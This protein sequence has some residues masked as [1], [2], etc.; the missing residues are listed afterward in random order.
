MK[1]LTAI[2]TAALISLCFSVPAFAEP[3][4]SAVSVASVQSAEEQESAAQDSAAQSGGAVEESEESKPVRMMEYRIDEADMNI[5][6]PSDMYVITRNTDENDPV[7]SLNRTDKKKVMEEFEANDIYLRANAKDFSWVV[8]VM[9]SENEDTNTIGS[10][11]SISEKNLQQIIDKL[12]ESEIYTGC[13][14]NRFGGVLFLTFTI[15][16]NNGENNVTGIQEYTIINGKNVRITYQTVAPA[17]SDPNKARLN[18][19]M[20][21][22][23]FDG[24]EVEPSREDVSHSLSVADIDIRYIYIIAAS[25]IGVIALMIMIITGIKYKRSKKNALKRPS[26]PAPEPEKNDDPGE[27]IH[28]PVTVKD[29]E[30]FSDSP[31]EEGFVPS[32][33]SYKDIAEEEAESKPMTY[34]DLSKASFVNSLEDTGIIELPDENSYEA[35]A[36]KHAE[37]GILIKTAAD[38][39]DEKDENGENIVFARVEKRRT[40]IEQVGD[41]DKLSS[42]EPEKPEPEMSEQEKSE[43]EKPEPEKSEPEKSEQEKPEP[44]KPEQEKPEPEPEKTEERSLT[45]FE[46]RFGKFRPVPSAESEKQEIPSEEEIKVTRP[47]EESVSPEEKAEEVR[48]VEASFFNMMIDRLRTASDEVGR[49]ISKTERNENGT[50]LLPDDDKEI[51]Q[52]MTENSVDTKINEEKTGS[53]R[54]KEGNTIELEISRSEDGSLVI[55]ALNELSGKPVDIEIR[56]ASNFKEERDRKMAELGFETARDNEIYNAFKAEN[57]ENPFVVRAKDES[58]IAE[59]K[60]KAEQESLTPETEEEFFEGVKAVKSEPETAEK[61]AEKPEETKEDKDRADFERNCGIIFEH[62]LPKRNPIIPMQT[63]FTRIPRLDSVNAEEYNAK[64]E[65][66]VRSMPKNHAYA[67]RFSTSNIPQ[68]FVETARPHNTEAVFGQADYQPSEPELN[69]ASDNGGTFE[70][71]TGYE[72]ADDPFGASADKE[73]LIKEHNRKKSGGS[74]GSR[75]RKFFSSEAQAPEDEE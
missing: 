73:I 7:L 49:E 65:E 10:L 39:Q 61:P 35:S 32:V 14:K 53:D 17:D 62:P 47:E 56:D 69:A 43:P 60:K 37:D 71:Y 68:P 5:S 46:K 3:E 13:A 34:E 72:Q 12:L 22:V 26:E 75:L 58:D 8:S 23:R 41:E 33:M 16:Y 51:I 59:E 25:I 52:D 64:Y 40:E 2:L 44:E 21:T 11:S 29:L 42:S 63:V 74:F 45:A 24:I 1:R 57:E 36:E 50:Q 6:I 28:E 30:A 9:E 4:D 70:Y 55:G 20:E 18:E 38:M 67:Q 66:M 15:E 27:K 54:N 48:A 31:V 19:I